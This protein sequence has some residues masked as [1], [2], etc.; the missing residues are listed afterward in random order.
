ML[1]GIGL[2]SVTL[3]GTWGAVQKIPAWVGGLPGKTPLA[4]ASAQIAS[5]I[6]AIIGCLIAPYVAQLFNRRIAYFLLCLGSL[7]S[8]QILFRSFDHYSTSFLGMV[9]L[10]GGIT[11]SVYGWMPLY[12]PELFP[13]RIRA[14]AQG[15]AYNFGR[16]VAG[17]GAI[18]GG[19]IGGSYAQMAIIVSMIYVVGMVLI[20][21][22]PET[23]GKPL[24][25]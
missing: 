9:L 20:W 4:V 11:A 25:E 13:T 14:T 15:I 7:I 12:L 24:P 5:G 6:G 18:W 3:L 21:F 19:T 2:A 16:I 17:G 22:A 23:K 8:C 10:T 1:L